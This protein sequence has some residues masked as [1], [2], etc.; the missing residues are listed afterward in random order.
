MR[1]DQINGHTKMNKYYMNIV[2]FSF[3]FLMHIF[4]AVFLLELIL[5]TK[6]SVDKHMNH[7]PQPLTYTFSCIDCWVN[8]IVFFFWNSFVIICKINDDSVADYK[9]KE[10]MLLITFPHKPSV[11][12]LCLLIV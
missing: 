7:V 8:E 5:T 4:T 10:Q 11:V 12:L 2:L 6:I 3:S 1:Q 9:V